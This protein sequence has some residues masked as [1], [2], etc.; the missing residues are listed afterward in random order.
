[1]E[2]ELE[3]DYAEQSALGMTLKM[4]HRL[5]INNEFIDASNGDEYDTI[6]PADESVC[7]ICISY[8]QKD[9]ITTK[10]ISENALNFD[11]L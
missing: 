6:N 2:E 9:L 11:S 4:P 7:I 3:V 10:N 5:F 1:M 8:I